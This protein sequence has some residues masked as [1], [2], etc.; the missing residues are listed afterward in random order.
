[1]RLKSPEQG[2]VFGCNTFAYV[3]HRHKSPTRGM[4]VHYLAAIKPMIGQHKTG[5]TVR[6]RP[7][8]RDTAFLSGIPCPS[9]LLFLTFELSRIQACKFRF[10]S[11]VQHSISAIRPSVAVHFQLKQSS[12][13]G[14]CVTD[15]FL[16]SAQ[17]ISPLR[18]IALAPVWGELLNDERVWTA[19]PSVESRVS[20]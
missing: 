11:K 12:D 16:P 18:V 3:C 4:L 2:S 1:M 9:Q 20:A 10:T 19:K 8:A 15:Y 6:I 17:L 13:G 7:S 14:D 5:V